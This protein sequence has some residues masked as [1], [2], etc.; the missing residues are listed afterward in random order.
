M[1]HQRNFSLFLNQSLS[2]PLLS[3]RWAPITFTL[4][5]HSANNNP[6]PLPS[7]G[8]VGSYFFTVAVP[9]SFHQFFGITC[10]AHAF[11]IYFTFNAMSMF[12]FHAFNTSI[13]PVGITAAFCSLIIFPTSSNKGHFSPHAHSV[14]QGASCI[15][16][17]CFL[18][19]LAHH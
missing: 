14:W 15:S 13:V 17:T 2:H 19:L 16:N 3:A 9:I 4:I 1:V 5:F 11:L 6:T 8:C 12:V 10:L 7:F 18:P